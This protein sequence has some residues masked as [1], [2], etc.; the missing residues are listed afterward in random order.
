MLTIIAIALIVNALWT[1]R[2]SS[3]VL[4]YATDISITELLNDTNAQRTANGLPALNLNNDLDNA[5]QAKANDMVTQNYWSHVN[6]EGETPWQ[7]ITAA[8]YDYQAAGEN[9]AYGFDSSADTVTGWMNSAEHRANIL[10]STYIDVGFG[11]ANSSNFQS[12]GPETVVVAE[13]AEPATPPPAAPV[14]TTSTPASTP[15]AKGTPAS[16]TSPSPTTTTAAQPDTTTTTQTPSVVSVTKPV[17]TSAT[18]IASVPEPPSRRVARIQ[19]L[20]TGNAPW[21]LF[22]VS[23]IASVGLCILILRHLRS[24]QKVVVSGEKFVIRHGYLDIVLVALIM[25]TFIL[26]RS[27]GVI[28]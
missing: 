11:F 16:V 13:Y 8:G 18:K 21:S 5:A 28:R 19:L 12:S 7:F 24:W 25:V 6:P 9:L 3:G 2:S 20:T 23:S 26:S 22:A 14:T 1:A 10:D 27:S 17:A 4:G 15:T